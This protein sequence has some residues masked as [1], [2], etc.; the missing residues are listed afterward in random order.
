LRNNC[1]KPRNRYSPN[2]EDKRSRCPISNYVSSQRLLEPLKA[3][4]YTLSSCHVPNGVHEA[5][6]DKKWAKAIEEEMEAL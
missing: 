1:G 6:N 3:F 5:V 2:V 4:V